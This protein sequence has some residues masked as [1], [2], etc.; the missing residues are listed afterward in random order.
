MDSSQRQDG[1]YCAQRDWNYPV[2]VVSW[3]ST[4]CRN[5]L[6]ARDLRMVHIAVQRL[7]GCGR[8]G[9]I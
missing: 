8:Y 4:H 7:L 5:T 6:R 2:A 1:Q 9:V 3:F